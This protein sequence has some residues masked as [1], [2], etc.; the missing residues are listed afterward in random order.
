MMDICFH[1]MGT[2]NQKA[3]N[4]LGKTVWGSSKEQI[5][6]E[7][8]IQQVM[9]ALLASTCSVFRTRRYH[10]VPFLS[11]MLLSPGGV[12]LFIV[13][14]AHFSHNRSDHVCAFPQFGSAPG[15]TALSQ[16]GLSLWTGMSPAIELD[17]WKC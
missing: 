8:G 11:S 7:D 5:L 16:A 3:A 10:S 14:Q 2:I 4:R 12:M 1:L 6:G 9:W 17:I 15:L 13:T